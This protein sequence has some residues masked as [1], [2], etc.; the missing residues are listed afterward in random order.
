[1]RKSNE[2]MGY[3]ACYECADYVTTGQGYEDWD[4][5]DT[6]T[7]VQSTM[8][9]VIGDYNKG[10]SFADYYVRLPS[11]GYHHCTF[12]GVDTLDNVAITVI[13]QPD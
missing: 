2:V 13:E 1:M 5:Y 10:A 8:D 9:A 4:D 3:M 7:E 11:T 12:C 6:L